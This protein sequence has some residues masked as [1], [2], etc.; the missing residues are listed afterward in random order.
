[1]ATSRKRNNKYLVAARLEQELST[2]QGKKTKSLSELSRIHLERQKME[3]TESNGNDDLVK[4]WADK[5][6]E[7]RKPKGGENDD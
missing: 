7:L 3:N 6:R 5:I 4:A 1:M 2:V